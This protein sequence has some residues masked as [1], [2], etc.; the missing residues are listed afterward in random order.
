MF[1]SRSGIIWRR[2]AEGSAFICPHSQMPAMFVVRRQAGREPLS[3]LATVN[4]KAL[5][6]PHHISDIFRIDSRINW[7]CPSPDDIQFTPVC[8][9]DV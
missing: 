5:K 3:Q 7:R 8:G 4:E 9:T 2:L 6:G 1:L